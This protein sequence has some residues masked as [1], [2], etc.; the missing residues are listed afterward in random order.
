MMLEFDRSTLA[1]LGLVLPGDELIGKQVAIVESGLEECMINFESE[2]GMEGADCA[3][4]SK[5]QY[6]EQVCKDFMNKTFL[7]P[8]VIKF[9]FFFHP[10]Q[11]VL[12]FDDDGVTVIQ[13]NAD[14]SYWRKIVRNKIARMKEKR[15]E[16]AAIDFAQAYLPVRSEQ[17]AKEKVVSTWG[18]YTTTSGSAVN[19]EAPKKKE[20][21]GV[22]YKS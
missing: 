6:R 10:F 15:R 2:E 21:A 13:P 3:D 20:F 1:P 18:P 9:D 8:K 4:T 12:V 16:K 17:E 5:D 11:A 14:G 22:V 7:A 19:G